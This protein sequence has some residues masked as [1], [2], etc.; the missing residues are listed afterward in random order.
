MSYNKKTKKPI[1]PK[2][3]LFEKLGGTRRK[4][5]KFYPNKHYGSLSQDELEWCLRYIYMEKYDSKNN[6]T[7][8]DR[9]IDVVN[10]VIKINFKKMENTTISLYEYLH[11]ECPEHPELFNKYKSKIQGAKKY[12]SLK[13][14][15]LGA[16]CKYLWKEFLNEAPLVKEDLISISSILADY[17]NPFGSNKIHFAS[18]VISILETGGEYIDR[19][20]N[21]NLLGIIKGKQLKFYNNEKTTAVIVEN[22]IGGLNSYIQNANVR[23]YADFMQKYKNQKWNKESV[24]NE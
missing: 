11:H 16:A 18:A 23:D 5:G 14:T 1:I 24:D 10:G 9:G 4:D 15:S 7:N 2:V 22:G 3:Y 19:D 8:S 20:K 13:F 6:K 21:K 12:H 17:P